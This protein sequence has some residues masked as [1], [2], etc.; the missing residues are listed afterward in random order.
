MKIALVTTTINI[1]SI[2]ELY[3]DALDWNNMAIFVAADE[4][5]PVKVEAF[6]YDLSNKIH[7]LTPT[8]QHYFGYNC[9]DLIGWNCIQR[10]NIATL[11]ALKWGA[12]V[13]FTFDDDNISN[14]KDFYHFEWGRFTGFQAWHDEGWFDPG[15][16]LIPACRHRGFPFKKSD[17]GIKHIVNAKV[18]V[19][20]GLCIGDPDI[21]ATLRME[22]EPIVHSVSELAREGVVVDPKVMKTVFNSQNTAF[23]RELAPAMFMLPGIGRYDDIVASL[24]AQ[25]VMEELGY[26]VHF[27]KPF[28]WQQRND[29]DLV[30]DL[31]NEMWGMRNFMAVHDALNDVYLE[32]A[33]SV[34]DKVRHLYRG[35]KKVLPNMSR[36]AGLAWCDDCERVMK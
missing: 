34:I 20:A 26:V 18:G 24:V 25:R 5:T 36:E 16:L 2:L 27:G 23:V 13:I 12:D 31:E 29:H 9:S 8:K 22:K 10:R 28:A 32:P 21:D 4:K 7:Y 33:L 1:P 19:M 15:T 35:L 30:K 17:I 14:W 11:E 6:C 3:K